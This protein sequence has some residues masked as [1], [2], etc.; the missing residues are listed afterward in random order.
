VAGTARDLAAF[1]Q[2]MLD[3]GSW[4]GPTAPTSE[5]ETDRVLRVPMRWSEGFQLGQP[6]RERYIGS[7]AD[8]L[9]FGHNGSN[10]CLGWAD[11]GRRLVVAYLTNRLGGRAG[12]APHQ[13]AV[14]DAVLA[15]VGDFRPGSDVPG[16]AGR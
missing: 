10:A 9:A 7:R 6:G 13:S 2:A 4:P 14:S 12:G 5:G 15:A 16:T 3:D 1:Y 8:P 11:P